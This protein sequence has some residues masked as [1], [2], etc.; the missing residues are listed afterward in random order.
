MV[1]CIFFFFGLLYL[2]EKL[3]NVFIQKKSFKQII[4]SK[5]EDKHQGATNILR[6][7]SS[8]FCEVEVLFFFFF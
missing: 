6:C 1:F 2:T 7:F 3:L 8:V 4:L 5:K